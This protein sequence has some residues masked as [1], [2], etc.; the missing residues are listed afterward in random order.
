[1]NNLLSPH[2]SVDGLRRYALAL[3]LFGVFTQVPARAQQSHPAPAEDAKEDIVK[4]D[5]YVVVTEG[6]E[7][8]GA[9]N[10]A[11]GSR[12]VKALIDIPSSVYVAS[13]ELIDDLGAT[14]ST[15]V[16]KYVSPGTASTDTSGD[17]AIIRGFG[18]GAL[19]DGVRLLWY[20]HLPMY[21]VERIEVVKG[22]SNMLIGGDASF[23]GGAMNFVT[24]R[25]TATLMSDIKVTAGTDSYLRGE[26]NISGPLVRSDDFTALYRFTVGG[27]TGTPV[28]PMN[29]ID[30]QF[31]G[32]AVSLA[33]GNRMRLDVNFYY[34][35]DNANDY[36]S[37]FLD[38]VRST[39]NGPAVL[40]P[41]ST[42]TFAP[43]RPD[44]NFW[45]TTSYV[46][47]A[48][49]TASLTE[50]GLLRLYY[51]HMNGID[52]RR[53]MRGG[54]VL[55]DNYTL[56]RQDILFDLKRYTK[57]LQADYLHQFKRDAWSND[58]Q[59]GVEGGET[60]DGTNNN[61]L[62]APPLD[63]RNPDLNGYNVPNPTDWNSQYHN[64]ARNTQKTDIG[65]YW[66]QDNLTLFRDKVILVGGLRW[67]DKSSVNEQG[68]QIIMPG[69]LTP[70]YNKTLSDSP[71]IRTHRYG[72]VVKPVAGVSLY[73]TD[74]ENLTPTPGF[75][76]FGVPFKDSA[77]TLQEYGLKFMRKGE[78]YRLHGSV[79]AFDMLQTNIR[80]S[81][82]DPS[83]PGGI[84]YSQT[85]SDSTEGWEMEL[86][87]R[88]LFPSGYLE[89]IGTYYDVTTLRAA[90][91]GRASGAPDRTYSLFGKYS[92]TATALN[93]LTIGGGVYDQSDL[94]TGNNNTLDYPVTYSLMARYDIGK[95]WA[96]QLNGMNVTDEKYISN[97]INT[98][99]V[100][101]APRAEYRVSLKYIW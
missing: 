51:A 12:T 19:R 93:G 89:V 33:F 49:F 83:I 85:K 72:V 98:G 34:F 37:D 23:S 74:A 18:A 36:W 86:G 13:R 97:A 56:T 39:A 58:I 59:V 71:L 30:E 78:R 92:W 3:A 1:M 70:A 55:A 11:I 82:P 41:N 24:R 88:L 64:V 66:F 10:A 20:K 45:D 60:F 40:N 79:A 48:A 62:V 50:N 87:G 17:G 81:T 65:S 7:G 6:D 67:S 54:T 25:P 101:V 32:G 57:T 5:Q 77:G 44:Q 14:Y 16:L 31:A 9:Q 52:R 27:E 96:V 63:T 53:T 61:L 21:D 8:Y 28:K 29:T 91:G 43:G 94:R 47:N 68:N 42:E 73:F 22:P 95:K 90:D 15:Q 75:D 4:L 80:T 69:N 26:A 76:S 99:L 2:Q 100:Q 35:V 46:V 84:R 38:V